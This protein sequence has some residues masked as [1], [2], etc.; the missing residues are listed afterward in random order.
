MLLQHVQTVLD[1]KELLGCSFNVEPILLSEEGDRL[2]KGDLLYLL[3]ER[4]DI[5]SLVAA[6]TEEHTLSSVHI[7]RWL[8]VFMK[9]TH[10]LQ[11]WLAPRKPGVLSNDVLDCTCLFD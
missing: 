3:H 5:S 8:V 4:D 2:W 10:T 11:L 9:G 7:E 6:V 1:F